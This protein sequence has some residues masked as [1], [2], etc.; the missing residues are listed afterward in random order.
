M[1]L[2]SF[3]VLRSPRVKKNIHMGHR[4]VWYFTVFMTT[5]LS[6]VTLIEPSDSIDQAMHIFEGKLPDLKVFEEEEPVD[7]LMK[8]G[9]VAA[10]DHHPIVRESIYWNLLDKMCT[11]FQ[12]GSCKRQR[13]WEYIDMGMMTVENIRHEIDYYNP[14]VDPLGKLYCS[15]IRD[16][17]DP[18]IL[19][20]S[21]VICSRIHPKLPQCVDDIYSHISTQLSTYDENRLDSKDTYRKLGLEMD[22]P[23]RELF[24][25]LAAIVR[26]HGMNVAPFSRIDNGTTS[27]PRWDIHTTSAYCAIDAFRKIDD[28]EK[29]EWNDKPCTPYF[30]GALCAKTDKDGNM[31]IEA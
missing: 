12:Y 27:H 6:Q 3:F 2:S 29:R 13:A 16:D 24:P 28:P 1:L 14:N 5:S 26:S 15:Q 20:R 31:I 7:A 8:W 10:K 11:E 30:G 18:C 9:K 21:E 17:K 22:A 19:D 25:Q 23:D 4:I